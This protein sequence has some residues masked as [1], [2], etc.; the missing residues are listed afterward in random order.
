MNQGGTVT[1]E[2]LIEHRLP[3]QAFAGQ[4]GYSLL[5]LP[6]VPPTALSN[7]FP[8]DARVAVVPAVSD[9][10]L[11]R[12]YRGGDQEAF[13]RLYGRHRA[14]LMR[15]VRR[16]ALDPESQ[17]AD[18]LELLPAPAR[19]QPDSLVGQEALAVAIA[20]ALEALP[21]LQREV[22][23]LRAETDLTLDEIAQVTGTNRETAKSRLRYGVHRLRAALEPWT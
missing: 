7:D 4:L 15:F 17:D 11:M 14:P 10:E 6:G 13:R 21:L 20:A 23:L 1:V 18:A 5:E 19:M 9:E 12:L 3:W 22:F 8:R 16:T 2:G